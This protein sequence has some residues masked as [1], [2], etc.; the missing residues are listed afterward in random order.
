MQGNVTNLLAKRGDMI[1]QVSEIRIGDEEQKSMADPVKQEV[2]QW[3]DAPPVHQNC[4]EA[5]QVREKETCDWVVT[6]D[7]V[8]SWLSPLSKNPPTARVP[9]SHGKIGA[10][11]TI[12]GAE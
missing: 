1:R 11:K 9:L 7:E 2:I 10:G 8:R 5:M 3:L 4:P 6:C 12:L